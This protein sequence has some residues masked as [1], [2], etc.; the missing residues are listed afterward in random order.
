[1]HNGAGLPTPPPSAVPSPRAPTVIE[2][3]TSDRIDADIENQVFNEKGQLQ[4]GR[5]NT[6]T[7]SKSTRSSSTAGILR[8]LLR[9]LACITQTPELFQGQREAGETKLVQRSQYFEF[10][11][12]NLL[13]SLANKL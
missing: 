5:P 7:R 3:T 6:T 13:L 11:R 1:M 2:Q 9:N 4:N 8:G 12:A 10:P